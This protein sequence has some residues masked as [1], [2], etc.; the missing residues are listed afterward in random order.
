MIVKIVGNG[1][2]GNALFSVIRQNIPSV[3]MVSRN[4]EILPCDV[5]ILAVPTQNQREVLQQLKGINNTLTI[6][7]TAKGI[8]K[9][10]HFLPHQIVKDTIRKKVEYYTLI[11]PGFAQEVKDEMPTLL[12]LGFVKNTNNVVRIRDL[13]QTD[14]FRIR[15][16]KGVMV[17]ELSAAFKNIYAIACGLVDGLGFGNNTRVKIL[18][19][20]IEEMRRLCRK[21]GLRIEDD[22]IAGT[23]GDLL[24]TANSPLSRNFRFGKMIASARADDVLSTMKSTVE[25]YHS[26][27]SLDYFINEAEMQLPLAT[28]VKEVVMMQQPKSIPDKFRD[29]V[30]SV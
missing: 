15:L 18:V 27:E 20:A 3:S 24:L 11:G 29:F 12:N 10:T 22:A 1:V 6:I 13:L 9:E 19:L 17:L 14:Y 23:V 4:E 30:K 26:L 28:F 8:E 21:L 2:W 5:V 7:N 25:G 16:T